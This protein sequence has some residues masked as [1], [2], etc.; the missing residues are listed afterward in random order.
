MSESATL[1]TS[2][3][4][5]MHR[6]EEGMLSLASLF[7]VLGFLVLIGLLANA[8]TVTSRK[9]ETQNAADA[10]AYS[11]SVEMAR[12]MNSVTAVNHLIGEL[13]ALVVLIHTL[14]GD[15][16]DQGKD[17]PPTPF[18]LKAWLIG[19]YY[20]AKG[21][22]FDAFP[23]VYDDAY[24]E[25]SKESQVGGAIYD[26]RK[27]LKMVLAWAYQTHFFGDMIAK[28]QYIPIVGPILEA[29]GDSICAAAYTF[30]LKVWQE[31]KI[32][33]V[34]EDLARQLQNVK[35]FMRDVVVP[36]LYNYEKFLIVP[37]A[38]VN[39]ID[40]T[41]AVQAPN[42]ADDVSLYPPWPLVNLNLPVEP[43]PD[44]VSVER[45]Q[46]MRASTPW[47]QWW[48]QPWM[49]F[50]KDVL[51]LSRFANYFETRSTEYSLS[52][53]KS[54]K[55]DKGINLYV[56]SNP[57]PQGRRKTFEPWTFADTPSGDTGGR[58]G[59]KM[60]DRMF[61]VVGL[62]QRRA[63]DVMGRGIFRYQENPDGMVCYAQAMVYNANPQVRGSG[64][65]NW[66]PT[67]GWDTL[68]WAGPA[69][70]YPG[71]VPDGDPA[72]TPTTPQPLIRLNWQSKL[73]PTSSERLT[74]ATAAA[75]LQGGAIPKVLWR[76]QVWG[77]SARTH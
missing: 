22:D 51:L 5:D 68:N 72:P 55:Q 39:A 21:V 4:R 33:N 23:Q 41:R 44:D 48:R 66:Q 69:P 25:A 3:S 20:A 64:D 34:L 54:L 31:C 53:V 57:D 2:A 60:A 71:P 49:D 32:L 15:E 24:E 77:E 58:E 56:M 16:L 62:A 27:R 70:E 17:P 76:T 38:P 65:D 45:S 36:G 46:L 47:V 74:E 8:G 35:V 19:A 52:I 18:L 28:G 59:S 1:P 29:F 73:V 6:G 30:E 61:S 75:L 12:G 67:A 42:L 13:T 40:A 11:A 37:A 7:V 43:E 14:G 9:L 10:V 26:A 63:P 50:G